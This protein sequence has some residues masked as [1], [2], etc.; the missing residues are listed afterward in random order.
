MKG[1]SHG[2]RVMTLSLQQQHQVRPRTLWL[3]AQT[4]WEKPS[5]ARQCVGG[6]EH[7][8]GV[9]HCRGTGGFRVSR[10]CE[11]SQ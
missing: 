6:A 2:E 11:W 4:P 5:V 8:G 10:S 7:R 1:K 3:Q 9:P